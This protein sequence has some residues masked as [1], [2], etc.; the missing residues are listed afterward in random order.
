MGEI[1]LCCLVEHTYHLRPLLALLTFT[2]Q[3][4]GSIQ[5]HL[6]DKHSGQF[7]LTCVTVFLEEMLQ[8]QRAVCCGS[9]RV[10]YE[11]TLEDVFSFEDRSNVTTTDD[12]F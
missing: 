9:F 1:S 3:N 12:T 7:T 8:T 11:R 6:L 10:S 2:P 4:N 5:I